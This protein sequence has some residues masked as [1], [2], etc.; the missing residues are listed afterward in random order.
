MNNLS[1]DTLINGV[2]ESVTKVHERM[3]AHDIAMIENYM[4]MELDEEGDV[5]GLN[6]KMISIALPDKEGNY[7]KRQIPL[8]AL[9]NVSSIELDSIKVKIGFNAGWNPKDDSM[10]VNVGATKKRQGQNGRDSQASLALHQDH[11]AEKFCHEFE[12]AD[13]Q[14]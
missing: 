13:C 6:P 11:Q 12:G 1:L 10:E 4:D 3:E 9:V 5:I 8:V 2:S 7:T 14:H